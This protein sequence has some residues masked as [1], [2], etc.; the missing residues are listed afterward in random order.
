[1]QFEKVERIMKINRN[2]INIGKIIMKNDSFYIELL[3]KQ[4]Y[5]RTLLRLCK[6]TLFNPKNEY[7]I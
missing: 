5:K 7:I 4:K 2:F 1:M 3:K 6:I